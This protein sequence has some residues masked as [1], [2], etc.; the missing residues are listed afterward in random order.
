MV[1]TLPDAKIFTGAPKSVF[2]SMPHEVHT[3]LEVPTGDSGPWYSKEPAQFFVRV[4]DLVTDRYH[5]ILPIPVYIAKAG[6]GAIASFLEA[7]I[8]SSGET[9]QDALEG[10]RSLIVD[11]YEELSKHRKVLGPTL[12]KEFSALQRFVQPV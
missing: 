2:A 10:L 4:N 8:H 12:M 7:N 9:V 3:T 5:V 11:T 1:I 6:D